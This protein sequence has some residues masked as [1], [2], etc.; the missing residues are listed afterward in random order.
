[1]NKISLIY[2]DKYFQFCTKRII[3]KTV[4]SLITPYRFDY[5]YIYE[6]FYNNYT[7]FCRKLHFS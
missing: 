4:T 2:S 3:Y 5:Y 1:M 7:P 6:H